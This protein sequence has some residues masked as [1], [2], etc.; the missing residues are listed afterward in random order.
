MGNLGRMQFADVIG[1][2]YAEGEFDDSDKKPIK[3]VMVEDQVQTICVETGEVIGTEEKPKQ[4]EPTLE[5]LHMAMDVL[6]CKTDI[7]NVKAFVNW[8]AADSNT[9]PAFVVKQ[10]M[11]DDKMIERFIASF[12]NYIEMMS[13]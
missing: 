9:S 3:K 1:N 5:S 10:A 8:T 12:H 4:G 6:G 13:R 7:E 11:K 2:V